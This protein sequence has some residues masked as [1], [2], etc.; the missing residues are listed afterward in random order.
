MFHDM[1]L[2]AARCDGQRAVRSQITVV[3]VSGRV[4]GASWVPS[5]S[6]PDSQ[7]SLLV[8]STSRLKLGVFSNI[9]AAL[10]PFDMF[11]GLKKGKRN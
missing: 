9:L 8:T 3:A 5:A 1:D 2:V 4:P 11:L 10:P 7:V 6:S